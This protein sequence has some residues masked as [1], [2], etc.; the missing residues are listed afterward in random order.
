MFASGQRRGRRQETSMT[1][2][3]HIDLDPR[4]RF[5]VETVTYQR[6]GNKSSRRAKTRSVIVQNQVIVDG[7]GNMERF[8]IMSRRSRHIRNDAARVRTVVSTDVEEIADVSLR[9][10]Q[11]D[12][13]A[14]LLVWLVTTGA[15]RR[16]RSTG[17]LLQLVSW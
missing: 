2:H 7:L 3:D 4:E 5:V 17:D 12:L 6:A 11:E 10:L 13:L 9:Q 1:P 15:E 16:S 8:E 14:I